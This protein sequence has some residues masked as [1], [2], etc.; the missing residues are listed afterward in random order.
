MRFPLAVYVAEPRR[1]VHVLPQPVGWDEEDQHGVVHNIH[2]TRGPICI[3]FPA[4]HGDCG[5]NICLE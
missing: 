3:S 4:S 1:T 2:K 5:T